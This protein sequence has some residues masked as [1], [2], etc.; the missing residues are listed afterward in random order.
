MPRGIAFDRYEVPR[1]ELPGAPGWRTPAPDTSLAESLEKAARGAT[2]LYSA[3]AAE[4]QRR[5]G[6]RERVNVGQAILNASEEIDRK[7]IEIEQNPDGRDKAEDTFKAWVASQRDRWSKGLTPDG[8]LAFQERVLDKLAAGGHRARMIQVRDLQQ[9]TEMTVLGFAKRFVEDYVRTAPDDQQYEEAPGGRVRPKR[10][11]A[12][13]Q[14][15]EAYAIGVAAGAFTRQEA[16][17]A[18]QSHEKEAA[19]AKA[20]SLLN[21]GTPAALARLQVALESEKQKPGSTFLSVVSAKDRESLAKMAKDE[22]YRALLRAQEQTDRNTRL[23]KA[24]MAEQSQEFLRRL[25]E[26]RANGTLDMVVIEEG[27]RA[28]LIDDDKARFYRTAK[29][30]LSTGEQGPNHEATFRRLSL[31]VRSERAN[32]AEVK[33]EVERAYADRRLNYPTMSGWVTVLDGKIKSDQDTAKNERAEALKQERRDVEKFIETVVRQPSLLEKLEPQ[34]Q[35]LQLQLLEELA[36]VPR[37]ESPKPWW[38]ANKRRILEQVGELARSSEAVERGL[39]LNP[40]YQSMADVAANKGAYKQRFGEL[41]EQRYLDD[42]AR[43]RSI[44]RTQRQIQTLKGDDRPGPKTPG[45][46]TPKP[47]AKQETPPAPSGPLRTGSRS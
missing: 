19:L 30:Q 22:D 5:A 4:K 24:L 31:L 9:K 6:L 39:L 11:E 20:H 14:L 41:W 35:A 27:L 46:G 45:G 17:K 38:Y 23:Q 25:E 15:E 13:A 42:M 36:A 37:D 44:E 40:A 43:M 8:S 29:E 7:L 10:S 12:Y 26:R 28:G 33:A 47:G 34:V 21:A 16:A 1:G 2:Q 3:W 18:L 32:P